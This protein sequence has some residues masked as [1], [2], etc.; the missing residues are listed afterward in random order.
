MCTLLQVSCRQ[1]ANPKLE[2]RDST[3]VVLFESVLC[4]ALIRDKPPSV[5][6]N[7]FPILCRAIRTSV[8]QAYP[9]W[10]TFYPTNAIHFL[11]MTSKKMTMKVETL[12]L[13]NLGMTAPLREKGMLDMMGWR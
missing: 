12:V 8:S 4:H 3:V 2:R 5:T 10:Y 13:G 6:G 9:V 7:T 11:Y 1:T